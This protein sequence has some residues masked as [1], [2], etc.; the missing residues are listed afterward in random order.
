MQVF[1]PF[2][3]AF[4]VHIERVEHLHHERLCTTWKQFI[5]SSTLIQGHQKVIQ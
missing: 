5:A 3:S 1:L 2:I 4:L